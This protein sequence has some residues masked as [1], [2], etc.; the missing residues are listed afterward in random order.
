MLSLKNKKLKLKLFLNS[1]GFAL[2]FL[3][4]PAAKALAETCAAIPLTNTWTDAFDVNWGCQGQSAPPSCQSYWSLNGTDLYIRRGN[5]M[6]SGG[7]N[8][9]ATSKTINVGV[10]PN[11]P[12]KI[13]VDMKVRSITEMNNTYSFG[14]I[15]PNRYETSVKY[16]LPSYGGGIGAAQ[17][18]QTYFGG[19]G[20]FVDVKKFMR[21]APSSCQWGGGDGQWDNNDTWTSYETPVF[22][23]G[24]GDSVLAIGVKNVLASDGCN[25]ETRMVPDTS[26]KNLLVCNQTP[27][28]NQPVVTNVSM[29][30][31]YT[32]YNTSSPIV[33]TVTD[34]NGGT[35]IQ[36]VYVMVNYQGANAG[37]YRGYLG[38]SA[39][40]FPTWG[41]NYLY[42]YVASCTGGG[43]AAL[44]NGYGSTYIG[45]WGC[46]TS[47]SGNTRTVTFY[48]SFN[49]TTPTTNNTLSGWA[50]D[51]E[52]NAP[53]LGWQP[54][55]TF[56]MYPTPYSDVIIKDSTGAVTT[57]VKADGATQYTITATGNYPLGGASISNHT[58]YINQGAS[59][60][61][62]FYW[63]P[64]AQPGSI[65][66]SG[67]GFANPLSGSPWNTDLYMNFLSCST[68]T[69]A[70][71]RVTNFVVSFKPAYTTPVN[72]NVL[73]SNLS[74]SGIS[75]S[76]KAGGTFSLAPVGPITIGVSGKIT[77]GSSC[78]SG[79]PAI[80]FNSG[81]N[82]YETQ[83]PGTTAS[84]NSSGNY[85]LGNVVLQP[86]NTFC[87]NLA[88]PPGGGY[89]RLA[90]AT[91]SS[92]TAS[93]SGNCANVTGASGASVTV[94]LGYRLVQAGGWFETML[95]DV[96]TNCVGCSPSISRSLPDRNPS[97]PFAVEPFMIDIANSSSSLY[98]TGLSI[99]K[100]DILVR[101]NSSNVKSA[102]DSK[103]GTDGSSNNYRNMEIENYSTAAL[104]ANRN[105]DFSNG[106]L[107]ATN[108]TTATTP[109]CSTFLSAQRTAKVYKMN[110]ACF[111]IMMN[112]AAD[113]T[114]DFSSGVGGTNTA[115]I[116][117]TGSGGIT[118]SSRLKSAGN[119]R[120]VLVV[121]GNVLIS[122]TMG[123]NAIV[124][125]SP[126]DIQ[127]TII[128]K[129]SITFEGNSTPTDT[130]VIVDGSLITLS[131]SARIDFAR[132]RGSN[133][134]YPATLIK[135]K[136]QDFV[137]LTNLELT[138]PNLS[139][140][141]LFINDVR[142]STQ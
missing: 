121:E 102:N 16:K 25:G 7:Y 45:G 66:C 72:G 125:V 12:Y 40:N 100:G 59:Q 92:G 38:W 99:A 20:G 98:S 127:A 129:G 35:N 70:T 53:V 22:T 111:S 8:Y 44:Y 41:G 73:Y 117:I 34:P 142:W 126:G 56:S 133:N 138:S 75:F 18:D 62:Y 50:M 63:S 109:S 55:G 37:Q 89:Y 122:K 97:S 36:S 21:N 5:H 65:A 13:K 79:A 86:T 81:N 46:S 118:F 31:P 4:I 58:V 49:F 83:A 33:A 94:N 82:V 116:Y 123:N 60:R 128:S 61:G 80:A 115:V 71:T 28:A 104:S 51:A 48:T 78:A 15:M 91:S 47:T 114:Y 17:L 113:K 9:G 93:I 14:S 135:Y 10:L 107:T 132:N 87:T 137:E 101:D 42:N 106:P 110:A 11:T 119:S 134:D 140:T 3:L 84:I 96:F 43:Y 30:P 57:S 108:I 112:G 69:T 139:E 124:P 23:T 27:A 131:D 95:G 88:T 105:V 136:V 32:F 54:F 67:G 19:G 77:D 39:Q 2:L 29:T 24:G 120:L 74:V 103:K 76:D 6:F 68:S 64:S 90:C 85:N 52:G 26:I 1:F 141:G 130:S